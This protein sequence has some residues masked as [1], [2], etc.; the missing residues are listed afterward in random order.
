MPSWRHDNTIRIFFFTCLHD[1]APTTIMQAFFVWHF[2]E[3]SL[4]GVICRRHYRFVHHSSDITQMLTVIHDILLV[5]MTI[6]SRVNLDF[7]L[8]LVLILVMAV[9]GSAM[10]LLNDE[11]DVAHRVL[12]AEIL[13]LFGAQKLRMYADFAGVIVQ[14]VA[15]DDREGLLRI[16][17]R[18]LSYL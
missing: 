3:L 15:A 8:L 5:Q 17:L 12:L 13:L 10:R 14:R 18:H 7:V 11:L 6:V 4:L 1:I 2:N 9:L 16:R